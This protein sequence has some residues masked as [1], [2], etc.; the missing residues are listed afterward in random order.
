MRPIVLKMTAFGAYARETEVPFERVG[1]GLFLVTGDTGAGKTTLFDAIMFA[2][3]GEASGS[4]RESRML[5]SDFVP[6]S[7]DTVVELRFMQAGGEYAVTRRI[8]YAK[9]RGGGE[10]YG[11]PRIDALL[12]EPSGATTE[13]AARV[14]ERCSAL[15]ELNA[16]QF[17]KIIMLAQG[18]F[19]QF[20]K[21]NSDDKN[22]ILGR[23]FDSAPYVWYQNLLG[24]ARDELRRRREAQGSALRALMED[25]FRMPEGLSAEARLMFAP[26]HPDLVSNLERLAAGDGALL[27]EMEAGR[28]AI[29][30]RI[31]ALGEQK[32]AAEAVNA[33]LDELEALAARVAAL[34]AQSGEMARR[35]EAL[36]LAERALHRALPAVEAQARAEAEVARAN[37]ELGALEQA[38]REQARALEQAE[39]AVREDAGNEARLGEL[40]AQLSALEKQL[41]RY[42]DMEK[43]RSAR[44]EAAKA[45]QAAEE[46]AAR[47][48]ADRA[49]ASES[50]QAAR[51]ALSAL[52]GIDADVLAAENRLE[53]ARRRSEEFSGPE[54]LCAEVSAIKARDLDWDEAKRALLSRTREAQAASETF[55]GL[56]QRFIADQAGL[57]AEG[58]RRQLDQAGEARCPV[59]GS[60]L[61]AADRSALA[62][63]V[64]ETPDR[65]AVDRAREAA[66]R[67][68][69]RRAAQHAKTEAIAAELQNRRSSA[70][71]RARRMIPGEPDWEA[72]ASGSLL[73]DA[74]GE[75][76]A[77]AADVERRLGALKSDRE[78][79]DAQRA[80]L[81][82][83]EVAEQAAREAAEAERSAH[84]EQR[85]LAERLE[86]VLQEMRAQLQYESEEDAQAAKRALAD[87][88]ESLSRQLDG[89][90]RALEA[91]RSRLDTS[92]GSLIEKREAHVRLEAALE[93]ARL[94]AGQALMETGFADELAARQAVEPIGAGDGEAWLRDARQMIAD[95]EAERNGA[96]A[97]LEQLSAQAAGLQ[98]VDM[99]AL[100]QALEEA[101]SDWNRANGAC[102]AQAALLENHRMAADRAGA[103][104]RALGESEGA[105]RRLDH[106]A[107]LA[108]GVSGAGGKL[109]FDRYVMGAVFREILEMANRR[110]D[111]MSQGRYELM[112]RLEADRA[113]AKAGL[114]IEV[115]DNITGQRRPSGSLSGG[116]AFFTSLALA[117]GLSDV[118]QNHAGGRR[119]DALFIDE[120]FG[121]LSDDALERALE[122]LGQ[123]TE[124]DRLVG[125]ISHVDKLDES[126][127]QKIRV[128]GGPE[129]SSISIETA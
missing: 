77:Q 82:K 42:A 28:D 112:H 43:Q 30:A 13:G 29:Q 94:A 41:P 123:L 25:G 75:A 69:A 83:L 34:D 24:E 80:R 128:R 12:V 116:E 52:E 115:L 103:A 67:A 55:N 72:L 100:S 19:R 95:Y 96:R 62:P 26:G 58:L 1:R 97:R 48:E 8:H 64:D 68:E 61:D 44:A 66:D 70:L 37:S 56:Y 10:Q 114:E 47:A 109:S 106:L 90:R 121:A 105:W 36:S 39:A 93:K 7:V 117:L 129:G 126:I 11:E 85:A 2:L 53:A 88:Q 18:E 23:L 86:A 22:R 74:A 45:A 16:D 101:R 92:R 79:R 20:L 76:A 113:S 57:L 17:R 33:R 35:S 78:R 111:R 14:T 89:H 4:D 108:V 9:K 84:R 104:V 73:D 107:S 6:K 102:V 21:A 120:G 71:Q 110:L 3:F 118:V 65:E 127:P 27:K 60:A 54:G 59:C 32:G 124:G 81:G 15:L 46:A 51:E 49:R 38:I 87:E 98:R 63:L 31:G 5:H 99:D 40:A 122:V 91:A 50:I 125:I 119:M